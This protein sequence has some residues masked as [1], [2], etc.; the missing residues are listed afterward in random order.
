[1]KID[2]KTDL[3]DLQK[4]VDKF[5]V[6]QL[7]SLNK[8]I[9]EELLNFTRDRFQTSTNP[10]G[11]KWRPLAQSTLNSTVRTGR[12][13]RSY[14]TRPLVRQSTLMN[15]FNSSGTDHQVI[16]I[17]TP[18]DYA[19]YHQG[20]DGRIPTRVP[21]RMILPTKARGLPP[22]YYQAIRERILEHAGLS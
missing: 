19:K 9:A 21:R 18:L 6:N 2:I 15:S 4:L 10:Y 8:D 13:R 12:K 22:A 7:R 20:E 16:V 1:M 17:G 14:G 3:A 11:F 5:S